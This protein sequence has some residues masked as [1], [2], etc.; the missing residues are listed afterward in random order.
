MFLARTA[1]DY[2][3]EFVS[4]YSPKQG[5]PL[6][7]LDNYISAWLHSGQAARVCIGNFAVYLQTVILI[8]AEWE[9]DPHF[10]DF[11]NEDGTTTTRTVEHAFET[12]ALASAPEHDW[13][14][15]EQFA[16]QTYLAHA[17][18]QRETESGEY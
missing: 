14:D 7:T 12:T 8:I 15:S 1:A 13:I 11:H 4:T 3:R 17:P 6:L 9:R 16:Y 10:L 2:F 5:P 18:G